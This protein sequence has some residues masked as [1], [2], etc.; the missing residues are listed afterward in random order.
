VLALP[1]VPTLSKSLKSEGANTTVEGPFPKGEIHTQRFRALVREHFDFVWRTLRRFGVASADVD[2]A[3]QEVFLVACRRLT[4]IAP[5]RERSF[6][7]GTSLRVA[8]TRR[9]NAS[10]RAE[11]PNVD[12]ERHAA[13][14]LDP[15]QL[16]ELSSARLVLQRILDTMSDDFRAVFILAEL[17]DLATPEIAALLDIPPGTVSSRLRSARQI[18]SAAVARLS[19]RERFERTR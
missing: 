19:A 11:D 2:D 14:E 4:D 17:E 3:S 1:G 15:E 9:R 7:F 13:L 18:F 8:S 5:E 16:T 12:F 6:L 10:R